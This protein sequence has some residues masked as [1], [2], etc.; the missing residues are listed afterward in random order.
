MSMTLRKKRRVQ[1]ILLAIV[2]LI[3]ATVLVGYSLKDGIAFFR[4]PTQVLQELPKETE[5]FRIGG[6][7][8]DGSL[9]RGQGEVISFTVTDTTTDVNVTF[10]GVLPDL[11]REGQGMIA[12]G[13]YVNGTF[14]ATEILA[15]HDENYIPKEVAEALKAQGVFKPADG[16]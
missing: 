2:A 6:L 16:G 13:M 8:K 12:M 3:G 11:F 4:S 1:L 5:V 9:V 15:K 7:V 14:Q 10:T